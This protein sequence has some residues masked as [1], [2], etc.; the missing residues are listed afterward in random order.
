MLEKCQIWVE[1]HRSAQ[2][3]FQKLNFC[4]SCQKTRKISQQIF[5]FLSNFPGFLY[6]VPNILAR[7]VV[8]DLFIFKKCLIFGKSKW[9]SAYFKY[10]SI[11]LNSGI[12]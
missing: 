9:S 11:A 8:P 12:Q 7:I 2:S 10:I 4:N 5:E 6:F 3:S 1:A